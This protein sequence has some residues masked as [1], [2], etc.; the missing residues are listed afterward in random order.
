MWIAGVIVFVVIV[1][2]FLEGGHVTAGL[3]AFTARE[4]GTFSKLQTI[5]QFA[6][7]GILAIC[8]IIVLVAMVRTG[9]SP[10]RI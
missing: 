5:T 6:L 10:I 3:W 7:I 4:D 9:F 1:G 8:T 2:Y